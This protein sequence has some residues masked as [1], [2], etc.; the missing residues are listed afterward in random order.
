MS[1]DP[2]IGFRVS[3]GGGLFAAITE[4]YK[5]A[6]IVPPAIHSLKW[7]SA[8]GSIPQATPLEAAL[9]QHIRAFELWATARAAG[10]PFAA[11]RKAA[12]VSALLQEIIRVL[13]GKE[14]LHFEQE[15][16]RGA[17]AITDLKNFVS[18]ATHNPIAREIIL[19]QQQLK[20]STPNEIAESLY[21]LIC[22]FLDL[23][24][25][26]GGPNPGTNRQKWVT[27]FVYRLFSAPASARSWANQDL[28]VVF[29]YLLKNPVLCR[30]GRF[31]A[32]LSRAEDVSSTQPK[33]VTL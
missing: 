12:A 2:T 30:I 11:Q 28:T 17:I 7:L 15:Y 5:T 27:E 33:V 26:S 23:P 3:E 19:L 9:D 22:S 25:F 31:A 14:W 4:K 10:S 24:A 16:S 6:I 18:P 1:A 32:L 21:E 29:G 8:V 20:E 13:C